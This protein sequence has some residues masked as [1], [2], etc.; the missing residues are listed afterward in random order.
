MAIGS[1]INT[2]TSS[3]LTE[4]VGSL[5]LAGKGRTIMGLFADVTI[6]EKHKD[7]LKLPNTQ[8]KQVQLFL[9]MPTWRHQSSR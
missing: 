6:E 8:L 5:L 2:V 7:E 4:S 3:L 9:I 1:L